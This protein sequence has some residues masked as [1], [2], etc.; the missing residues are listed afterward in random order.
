MSL[1]VIPSNTLQV[2]AQEI[3][4]TLDLAKQAIILPDSVLAPIRKMGVE[5]LDFDI[6]FD[7]LESWPTP[8]SLSLGNITALQFKDLVAD[9]KTK[10]E[11]EGVVFKARPPIQIGYGANYPLGAWPPLGYK[12]P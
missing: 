12:V 4:Y 3:E 10:L 9:L 2:T 8:I 6:I 7:L 11:A 5:S 1:T